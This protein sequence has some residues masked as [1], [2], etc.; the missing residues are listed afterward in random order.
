MSIKLVSHDDRKAD[1]PCQTTISPAKKGFL[2]K[3]EQGVT[4]R[5]SKRQS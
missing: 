5:C 3:I 4:L 1:G 2:G